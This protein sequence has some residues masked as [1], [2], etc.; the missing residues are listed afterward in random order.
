[1]KCYL[2]GL[3][4]FLVV[5]AC[6]TSVFSSGSSTEFDRFYA[7]VQ[8]PL[9]KP[10]ITRKQI[11]KTGFSNDYYMDKIILNMAKVGVEFK[12]LPEY[13]IESGVGNLMAIRIQTNRQ[14]R[15]TKINSYYNF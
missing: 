2:S 14:R 6:S 15:I 9:G 5:F 13:I 12:G 8:K 1:M 3:L 7:E 4:L 10:T 11:N